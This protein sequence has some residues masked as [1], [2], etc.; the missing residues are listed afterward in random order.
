MPNELP[1]IRVDNAMFPQVIHNLVENALR[2]TAP[3]TALGVSAWTSDTSV[4]VKVWDE[5]AGLADD[6]ASR[7]FERFYRGRASKTAG[8]SHPA[9]SSTGMGLGLTICEGIIR[10]HG[11]RI[12]AEPNTPRGVSFLV[13]LP[14]DQPQ[15][16]LPAREGATEQPHTSTLVTTAS[17]S[18]AEA[19]GA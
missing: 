19:G 13:S 6:E 15:P 5:G 10:A 1:M 9:A 4:V 11:G 17:S 14:I 7:V 18:R 3:G 16:S 12:W 8:A 2:Y